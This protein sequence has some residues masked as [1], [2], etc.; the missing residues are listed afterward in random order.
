MSFFETYKR[1]IF[2]V[3]TIFAL[4]TFSITGVMLS[5]IGDAARSSKA[6]ETIATPG[7][8]R[9]H[10]L[11]DD[12]EAGMRVARL[13]R[14]TRG[15]AVDMPAF[16]FSKVEVDD[17]P[18]A[19]QILRRMA[20]ESGIDVSDEDVSAVLD[21]A[22]RQK[23]PPPFQQNAP[24]PP[25]LTRLQI[26]GAIE[27][28]SVVSLEETVRDALRISM[29][30]RTEMQGVDLSEAAL[31]D[32]VQ[33]K[34]KLR[35]LSYAVWDGKKYREE[36][37]RNPPTNPELEA[38]IATLDENARRSYVNDVVVRFQSAG[39]L[40]SD[41][42]PSE[43]TAMLDGVE[44]GEAE[45]QARY[46]LDKETLYK[47]P[48]PPKDVSPK[49]GEKGD[50]EKG[51]GEKGDGE[52]PSEKKDDKDGGLLAQDGPP[53]N[54]GQDASKPTEQG[55]QGDKKEGGEA[56]KQDQGPIGPLPPEQ[57][58]YRR[59][60]EV[61]DEI[62]RKLQVEQLLRKLSEAAEKARSEAVAKVREAAKPADTPKP[63]E[64][65]NPNDAPE[66]KDGQ[67]NA[68][69]PKNE[70]PK[71]E[72][73]DGGLIAQD[74]GQRPEGE[75]PPQGAQEQLS[76][77]ERAAQMEQARKEYA[78]FDFSA[79]FDANMKGKK[80]VVL[81]PAR[82]T[83]APP[84]A[85]QDYPPFG[86]WSSYWALSQ[87]SEVGA[88]SNMQ[89]AEKGAFFFRVDERQTNVPKA[90]DE[91]RE[92]ALEGYYT[93]KATERAKTEAETFRKLVRS[94]AEKLKGEEVTKLKD[95]VP[96]DIDAKLAKWREGLQA[97][98]DRLEKA[99]ASSDLPKTAIPK[100]EE[101]RNDARGKLALE[102]D[103]RQRLQEAAD[104][105]LETEIKKIVEP[106][107]AEAFDKAVT[108]AKI[109]VAKLGPFLDD[110]SSST[111][112]QALEDGAEK[113]LTGNRTLLD[114]KKGFVSDPLEDAAL[115]RQY[116]VRVDDVVT[117]DP[118][119]LTRKA[120][121]SMR[122]TFVTER[123]NNLLTYSFSLRALKER[124]GFKT[125]AAKSSSSN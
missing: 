2:L 52:K 13:Q 54:P 4:V 42:D 50:G 111:R 120:M 27:A 51:D 75:V 99:L 123:I 38:W 94:E 86:K 41:F 43:W 98:V 58:G 17:A 49:D 33:Q 56:G 116:V 59:V 20:L 28:G 68:E 29:L 37:E 57:V 18:I 117:G 65:K 110:A 35:S 26:A 5:F 107:L 76:S 101:Q 45:I 119:A 102:K 48:D 7:G 62:R 23:D 118:S 16:I 9:V 96:A 114:A 82:P 3:L 19:F 100:L 103:E 93:S 104:A 12:Y 87:L 108:E 121:E 47:L 10:L 6:P 55:E 112:Y 25:R 67:P 66:A 84:D 73:K 125:D 89:A 80:G 106:V 88:L 30:V 83:L 32:Y 11:L 85:F 72:S 109:E 71:N 122:S 115:M 90:I 113:F 34:R 36:L 14:L 81:V 97:T 92:Q 1:P 124:Y 8:E 21:F 39:V 22:C 105:K 24:A 74:F 53:A 69:S 78:A 95:A 70:S 79:W 77:Q 91:V 31:A 64:A 40:Y 44:I 63:D 60:D 15:G 61:K 46:D